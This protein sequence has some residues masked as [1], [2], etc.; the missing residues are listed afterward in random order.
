MVFLFYIRY[1]P[2]H[3][4]ICVVIY[5]FFMA[6]CINSLNFFT[7]F[8]YVFILLFV[9]GL[10]VVF[11]YITSLIPNEWFHTGLGVVVLIIIFSLNLLRIKDRIESGAGKFNGFYG[12]N[13]FLV[14]ILSVFLLISFFFVIKVVFESEIF[15]KSFF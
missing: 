6:L 4:I 11:V 5:C 1:H 7:W 9:G 3:I 8:S 12:L 10:I 13:Y 2:L 14:I 15:M